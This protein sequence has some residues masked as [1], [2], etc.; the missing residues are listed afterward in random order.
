MV[1]P[2]NRVFS[3]VKAYVKERYPEVNFQDTV[4]A[5]TPTLPAVSVNL[6]DSRE[7]ALDLSLGDPSEDYAV[8]VTFEI[9]CYS[10][11]SNSEARKII[12]AAC[13]AMRGMT[14]ARTFG[15]MKVDLP[16]DANT[17]R[18]IAR[19]QRIVGSL[20]ELPKYQGGN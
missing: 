17:F 12:N 10:N 19:F 18:Y 5:T 8:N 13:D 2:T 7:T 3:N 14:F 9:Q 1:D 11:K 6:I 15:A 20:D 4:T 16:N